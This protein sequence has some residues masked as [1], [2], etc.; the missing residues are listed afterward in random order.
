EAMQSL[1][2]AFWKEAIGDEIGYIMEN[3]TWID[4]SDTVYK[5][6]LGKSKLFTLD[7]GKKSR[8]T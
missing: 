7:Q 1:D 6:L 4:S 8:P 5:I 2:A 3:N